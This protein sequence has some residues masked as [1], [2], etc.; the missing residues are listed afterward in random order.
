MANGTETEIR[1]E[2]QEADH[3]ARN[4]RDVIIPLIDEQEAGRIYD[5]ALL[6][7]A[8]WGGLIGALLL[9]WLGA[10]MANGDLP[11][12]GLGQWAASGTTLGAVTGGG[13]GLAAGGLIGA[14]IALYR[15]PPRSPKDHSH[16]EGSEMGR[17]ANPPSEN[18]Q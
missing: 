18:E 4:E 6:H 2:H 16:S 5:P 17:G 8:L 3:P 12:A 1:V 9:G 10:A 11:V 14:L 13:V 15:L 7:F